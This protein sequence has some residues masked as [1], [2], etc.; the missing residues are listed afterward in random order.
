MSIYLNAGGHGLPATDTRA[1]MLAHAE[2][3]LAGGTQPAAEAARAEAAA[4]RKTAAGLLGTDPAQVALGNTTTQFWLMAVARLPLAGRRVLVS[5]HE[6]GRHMRYL[7]HVAPALGLR[8]DVVPE[9]EALDPAAWAA[10]ID[11]DLAAILMQHVTSAQGIVYPVAAVGALPRPD[12]TLLVVDA[13]Q[14]LGRL[15]ARLSGLNCDLLIATTRKWMRAPRA[16]AMMALS[17][18]AET[19]LGTD[20]AGLEPMDANMGLRL[21]MGVAL[22]AVERMGV[23]EHAAGI[24]A[25]AATFRAALTRDARLAEWLDGGRPN[26]GIAPGHITLKVPAGRIADVTAGLENAGILTKWARP[27]VEEPLSAAAADSDH[28]LLR[29]TPHL[30]NTA[31]EAEALT[32]ALTRC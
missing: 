19:V 15:V 9:A 28:A 8:L 13:A 6:W 4:V 10:R 16:T 26:A 21:G 5:A 22:Q 27:A 7:Q 30:Y 17:R 12:H 29:I 3:E 24:A 1:R 18:R 14:S 25:V 2:A 20:A 11:D 32:A 23:A 31:T